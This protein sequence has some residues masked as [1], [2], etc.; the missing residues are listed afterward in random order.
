MRLTISTCCVCHYTSALY[1]SAKEGYTSLYW[2]R[3]LNAHVHPACLEAMFYEQETHFAINMEPMRRLL[4]FNE[5]ERNYHEH[6]RK[7][8]GG[9]D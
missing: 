5:I 2:S 6:Q 9:V 8:F 4:G 7:N 1:P 3:R